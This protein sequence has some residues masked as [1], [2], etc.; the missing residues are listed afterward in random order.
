MTII[1]IALTIVIGTLLPVQASLNSELT[2]LLRHPFLGAFISFFIGTI[3]LSLIILFQRVPLG[4]LRRLSDIPLP[5][6]FGGMLGAL[7]VGSSIFLIPR[8]GPT[9]LMGAF[10]TGQLIGSVL[11]DHFGLF[12]LPVYSIT[13]QRIIGIILLFTGLFLVIKKTAW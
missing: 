5:Y 7:F 1:L 13:P 8:L 4:D 9:V 2:R 11:I 10:V 6:Y 3:T 12:N